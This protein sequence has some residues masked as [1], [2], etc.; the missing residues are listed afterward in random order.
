MTVASKSFTCETEHRFP[1]GERSAGEERAGERDSST[2]TCGH[3]QKL[4]PFNPSF[5]HTE[6]CPIVQWGNAKGRQVVG[7]TVTLGTA[8]R[9]EYKQEASGIHTLWGQCFSR[10][11]LKF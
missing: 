10:F 4:H 7:D 5:P 9:I 8:L 3:F 2:H 1:E 11:C 6:R